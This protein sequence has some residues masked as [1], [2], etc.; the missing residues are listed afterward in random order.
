MTRCLTRLLAPT[1]RIFLHTSLL[2]DEEIELINENI[3]SLQQMQVRADH[4]ESSDT[5]LKVAG[6]VLSFSW[7]SY[8]FCLQGCGFELLGLPR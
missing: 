1:Y 8:F 7:C 2:V 3:A 5:I 6:V 4:A